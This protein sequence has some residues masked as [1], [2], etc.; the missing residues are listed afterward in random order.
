MLEPA[1]DLPIIAIKEIELALVKL[2]RA[3]GQE[4]Y[5]KLAE[6]FIGERGHRCGRPLQ[7]DYSQDHL[8][9]REQSEIIGHAVRAMYLYSGVSDLAALRDEPAYRQT[10]DA[11]WRDVVQHKMYLTGGVGP[12]GGNEGFTAAYDLPNESAYAET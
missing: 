4:R 8:P 7:G 10:L 12:S 11:I 1:S 9:V 2:W 5:L 6:F 3:T